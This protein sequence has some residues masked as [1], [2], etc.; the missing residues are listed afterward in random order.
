MGFQA[1]FDDSG[2]GVPVF[3]LSGYVSPA[4]WWE[5]FSKEWQALLDESPT[6]RYFKMREAAQLCDEF[7]GMKVTERNERI[8]KFFRLIR[9]A[10]HLSVSSVIPIALFNKIWKG[11]VGGDTKHW[12]DPYYV[13]LWDI[14]SLLIEQHFQTRM[15]ESLVTKDD[16]SPSAYGTLDFIFDDN[17]RLAA[18][19]PPYYQIIRT[20]LHPLFRGWIGESPRF[21]N[22]KDHLPLQACDAQSWYFRR[23]FA[24]RFNNEPF[25]A[26]LPK[27]LFA[28][29]DEVPAG[30]S[31]FSSDR[32]R[33][34][35]MRAPHEQRD[36]KRF[37]DI[38]D[39]L[40]NGDF[41][42]KES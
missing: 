10:V 19:V 29:L 7:S 37:R 25:K 20:A 27:S 3:V 16:Q 15:R 22:D 14:V 4:C 5:D 8:Q 12:D 33:K 32:M 13:A 30:M 18:I 24:E 41:D 6:L 1:F 26:D 11:N 9:K 23:L 28:A 2:S 17:P 38:H 31:F 42:V 36:A 35:V 21:E 40:A 34:V 39:V